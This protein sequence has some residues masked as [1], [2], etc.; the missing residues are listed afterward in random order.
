MH[1]S[2]PTDRN[3]LHYTSS[4]PEHTKQSIVF[5]Q[6]LRVSRI[7]SPAENCRKR[8]T[9][10]GSWFYKWCYPK[11]I[12]EK[13]MG[14]VKFSEYTRKNK[15]KKKGV[16]FARSIVNQNLYVLYMNEEV[17]SVSTTALMISF[18]SARKL[19]SYLAFRKICRLISV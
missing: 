8:T 15:R 14:N 9:E 16:P 3:R 2:K 5:S 19:S 7:C 4:D 1:Y 6:S 13:E 12:A 10:M 18:G 11:G 17:K